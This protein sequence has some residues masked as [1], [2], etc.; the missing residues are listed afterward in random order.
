MYTSLAIS[1][2]IAQKDGSYSDPS[3]HGPQF[4]SP[5]TVAS[6]RTKAGFMFCYRFWVWPQPWHFFRG[7]QGRDPSLQLAAKHYCAASKRSASLSWN[8]KGAPV[9]AAVASSTREISVDKTGFYLH[10]VIHH[11]SL[12]PSSVLCKLRTVQKTTGGPDLML[13]SSVKAK[14]TIPWKPSGKSVFP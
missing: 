6:V 13:L 2:C 14:C 4:L 3:A 9:W 1:L 7:A 5:E 11:N 10:G 12:E 8:W